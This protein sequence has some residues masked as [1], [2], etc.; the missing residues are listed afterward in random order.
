MGIPVCNTKFGDEQAAD[1]I[2][3]RIAA[4]EKFAAPQSGTA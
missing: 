4:L 2:P 3:Q 1:M